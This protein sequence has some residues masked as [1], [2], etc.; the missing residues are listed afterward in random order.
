M[1][2]LL[3]TMRLLDRSKNVLFDSCLHRD[4]ER[5]LVQQGRESDW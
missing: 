2:G 1:K 3:Q 4:V 5:M